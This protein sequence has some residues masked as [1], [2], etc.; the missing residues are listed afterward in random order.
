MSHPGKFLRFQLE[1]WIQRGAFHQLLFVAV[2]I[3]AISVIGGLV[4]W[5]GTDQFG[6]PLEGI[7]WSFLRLT[8]PGYLGDD[9]GALLR[10]V[11]TVVTVLGY[12]LFMGSLIA[13]MTQWLSQTLRRFE[14]GLAPI[15]MRKHVV[16]LGWT[17]RTSELIRQLL[18]ARGR[19]RRFLDEHD[20]RMIRVVVVAESM[21]AEMRLRLRARLGKAWRERQIFLRAGSSLKLM[22]LRQFD[23]ERAAAIIVPGCEFSFG[24]IEMSD[25]RVVKTLLH[26]RQILGP[27]PGP[28]RAVIVAELFDPRRLRAS[29]HT[30]E[31]SLEVVPGDA[32]IA[33]LLA[34][35]I[36]DRRL[37]TV[38]HELLSH[39]EGCSLYVR[40][41]PE[42]AGGHPRE[43]DDRFGR[44]VVIGAVRREGGRSVTHLNP[45]PEF[46]LERDDMLALI[47]P[48]Y[49]D[50]VVTRDA[51]DPPEFEPVPSAAGAAKSVRRVLVLGW[52]HKIGI[53]LQELANSGAEVALTLVSR[54]RK[55]ER[56]RHLQ[57][58]AWDP[59]RVQVEHVER[60]YAVSGVLEEIALHQF[61]SI[62]LLASSS[63]ATSEEAD[64]R[65]IMGYEL[66]RSVLEE[67]IGDERTRPDVIVE[68]ADRASAQLFTDSKD[69]LLV[70]TTI[71]AYLQVHVALRPELNSVFG[72][73]FAPGGAEVAIRG[74]GDYG[75]AGRE[76]DFREI[77]LR[78][79]TEGEIALGLLRSEATGDG[80]PELC[81]APDLRV[82]PASDTAIIVL[83]AN[84]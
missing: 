75:L 18:G 2:L 49:D 33:R 16:V 15:S 83:A 39:H 64:A 53:V 45:P 24:G 47:A 13:I 66:L 3:A 46:K 34:Q 41:F 84:R 37:A 17:D 40:T 32:V 63:M 73:L 9:E 52:S 55:A 31:E 22:S 35:S 58:F 20:A 30:L 25:A 8:D 74:P 80:R 60:D 61:D 27:V 50:C 68:F 26:L 43:L 29:G 62:V 44:A 38:F 70:T 81:P 36:R 19:M 78:A 12:V 7:W 71:L 21:N 1:R 5:I 54:M 77:E 59:T 56:E 72:A 42:L 48:T 82:S 4:A 6:S 11:S 65:T 79:T 28:E 67:Q 23:L 69:V 10:F 51:V 14:S 76:T 57:E